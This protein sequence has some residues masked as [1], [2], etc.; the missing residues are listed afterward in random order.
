MEL[1]T[2]SFISFGWETFKK[3]PW[4][5]VGASVVVLIVYLVAGSFVEAIDRLLSGN[6]QDPSLVGSLL[7]LGLSTL[8]N[9][10]VTAFYLNAHDNPETVTLSSLWHPQPFWNFLGATILT[11]LAI[12]V[13]LVLLI[14]PGIIFML[15]YMFAMFIVIDRGLGPIKAMKE[16][17]RITRGYK[18]QLLG[19]VLVLTVINLAGALALLVGLLVTVPVTSLAFAHAYRALSANAGA[20]PAI[21]ADA[22]LQSN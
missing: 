2:G 9:M 20:P 21:T 1:S 7:N 18:W 10:G 19:F 14:V 17:T 13:G 4:F 16:S 22:T 12:V 5:F 6:P 15:M 11:G 3:R 8:I